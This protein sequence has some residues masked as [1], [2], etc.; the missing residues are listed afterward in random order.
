[1]LSSLVTKLFSTL[2]RSIVLEISIDH[3]PPAPHHQHYDIGSFNRLLKTWVVDEI[4]NSF[5]KGNR[6]DHSGL[7]PRFEP[8]NP[9][10]R[11]HREA[12]ARRY[13]L[14]VDEVC[15]ISINCSHYMKN[16]YEQFISLEIIWW[17]L[18]GTYWFLP[19]D[20]GIVGL[21]DINFRWCGLQG[22]KE[23]SE[24]EF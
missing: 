12:L 17:R 3:P 24:H 4:L 14:P 22:L 10:I 6:S 5:W 8:E 18:P 1:M 20:D 11:D 13:K 19:S 15:Y 16:K 23:C 2:A 9:W 21:A 7:P